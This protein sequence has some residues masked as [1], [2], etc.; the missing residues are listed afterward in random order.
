MELDMGFEFVAPRRII[1]GNGSIEKIQAVANEFGHKAL[2]VCG[3]GSVPIKI[4]LG[5]LDEAEIS[6]QIFPVQQEPDIPTIKSGLS[7]AKSSQCEF[8]IGYGGGSVLDTS[9]A[10]SAL[11]T[12]AGDIM[13]YLE[14]IGGG[15]EISNSAAPMIALPTTAGT[16]TEVTRNAVIYSPEHNVKVS[17]R[18]PLMVPSVAIIDPELTIT[19]PP[20]I[21]ASTGMDAL[22]QNLEGYVSNKANP[23]TDAF[24]KEGIKYCSK[25]LLRAYHHGEDKQARYEMALASLYGGLV[26]GNSGLGAVH[27]FAGP[28]GG[29]F[30]APH[31]LICA[32]LLPYVMKYNA[33]ELTKLKGVEDIQ[34]RYIDIARWV[35]GDPEASVEDGVSWIYNLSHQLD[36]PRLRDIGIKKSYFNRIIEESKVSSSMQKNPIKLDESVLESILEEAL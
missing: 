31:G 1:F 27:G 8:V 22:T 17:M 6:Y 13:D 15:K 11:M 18:S 26:L 32:S 9:K 20:S 12:N 21:T 7:T 5:M 23:M 4:L 28:M 33:L 24:A 36:I 19:M 29:I 16:G 3:S 10:I 2:V 14:V 25:A 35:T 30:H 34:S